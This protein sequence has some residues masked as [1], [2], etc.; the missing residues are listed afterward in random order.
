MTND[1]D[2]STRCIDI[3]IKR[4]G[5]FTTDYTSISSGMEFISFES[6]P[7]AVKM[8]GTFSE[9]C[10]LACSPTTLDNLRNGGANLSIVSMF[11]SKTISGAFCLIQ[12]FSGSVSVSYGVGGGY[13]LL[14]HLGSVHV[15]CRV[16]GEGVIAIG[17]KTTVNQA[18]IVA[19]NSNIL[20]GRDGLWSDGIL[21]QGSD[22]HGIVDLD[23]RQIL[24]QD[25]RDIIIGAHVW[26]G[27]RA[28]IMPNVDVGRGGI[29]GASSVVTKPVPPFC[30]VAGN[31]ARIVREKVSWCRPWTHLDPETIRFLDASTSEY[32]Q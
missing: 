29:V 15:D 16:A 3:K 18:R 32:I 8:R 19:V 22:Q 26:V 4:N 17:D 10:F 5:K 23:S 2:E 6:M 30:A 7:D 31:P 9:N 20:V 11:P 24:N 28:T 21:L 12:D 1:I 13:V 25:K 27:R 14:G